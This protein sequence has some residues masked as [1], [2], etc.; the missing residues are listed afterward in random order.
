M[1]KEAKVVEVGTEEDD[2]VVVADEYSLKKVITEVVKSFPYVSALMDT[3][4]EY[5]AVSIVG[6]VSERNELFLVIWKKILAT[7]SYADMSLKTSTLSL[8]SVVTPTRVPN[9]TG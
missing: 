3:G 7:F 1:N 2:L 4:K 6:G 9:N 8:S 5:V